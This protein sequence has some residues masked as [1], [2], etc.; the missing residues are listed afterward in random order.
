VDE[1]LDDHA[2]S[3]RDV[4]SAL[5]LKAMGTQRMRVLSAY[6]IASLGDARST[7]RRCTEAGA[8]L[9]VLDAV[10]VIFW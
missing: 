5:L 2:V 4:V 9:V 7:P 3:R 1:R 6:L 10:A 8:R